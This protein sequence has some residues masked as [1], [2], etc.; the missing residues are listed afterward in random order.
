MRIGGKVGVV[1]NHCWLP[2]RLMGVFGEECYFAFIGVEDHLLGGAPFSD[3][4][5]HTL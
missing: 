4:G 3:S 1:G 5:G 2:I